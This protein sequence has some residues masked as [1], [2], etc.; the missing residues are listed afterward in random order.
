MAKRA[1]TFFSPRVNLFITTIILSLLGLLFV[2][3]ASVA[4]SF[5]TFGNQ[6]HFLQQ[7]AIW[8]VVGFVGMGIGWLTP[9]KTWFK[10][11]PVL[12]GLGILLLI[13]VF[14]PGI[15]REL[16]GASRWLFLGDDIRLQPAELSKFFLVAL[17]ASFLGKQQRLLPFALITLLP[18][19]LILLQP[20]LGSALILLIIAFGLYFLADGNLLTFLGLGALGVVAIF[21]VINASNYR[22]ER[23]LTFLH[24]E[25]DPLGSGFHTR[26]I[27]L[28]LGRGG[29]IGQGIGNSR[30]KFSYI[31]EASTDSIFAI[32]AEEIGFIG[33]LV[34]IT[35]FGLYTVFATRVISQ[36]SPG[37][38][39]RLLG[40]GI[41]IWVISQTMLNLAAVVSLVPLTGIPLP[42]F[43]YGGSSLVMILFATGVVLRIGKGKD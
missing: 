7:Q 37:S 16:N 11:A 33:S 12:Y 25:R 19:G 32:I 6:Y 23:F 10:V 34:L 35:L 14:V 18:V 36:V 13:A 20:D 5:T 43:S 31:P 30:Q 38:S 3:D 41:V 27:T 2:F 24:P 15:G 1:Q 22:R 8:L 39:A 28:A 4:E 42:F 17:L 29:W 40:W 21:L 9:T 26:Q